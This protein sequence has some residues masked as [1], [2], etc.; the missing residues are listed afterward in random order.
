MT[1]EDE[2]GK[3]LITALRERVAKLEQS[4]DLARES[5]SGHQAEE[6]FKAMVKAFD[7]FIYVC[8]SNYEIEF[9]NQRFIHRIGR[10]PIGEKCYQVI[11]EVG[12]TCP[13]CAVGTLQLGEI[14]RRELQ[15]PKDGRWYRGA[16]TPIRGS[17]NTISCLVML[18]D[19][20]ERKRMQEALRESEQRFRSILE[21][22]HTVVLIIDPETGR[23]ED[24][25]LGACSF[26]G[27]SRDDLRQRN[28]FD[29]STLPPQ[30]I[31]ERKRMT[32]LQPCRYLESRHR[33]ASG[34]FRDV[35]VCSCPM[36]ISGKVLVFTLVND[37]TGRKMA[38]EALRKSE[39]RYRD[40][41]D[42]APISIL[43]HDFSEVQARFDRLRSLGVE[44]FKT[45]FENHPEEVR[46]CASMV[47]NLGV[48][49]ETVAL[50][51]APGKEDVPHYVTPYLEEESWNVVKDA[52]VALAEGK[53]RFEGVGTISTLT[54]EKKTLA[55]RMSVAE[56][57]ENAPLRVLL[58]LIDVTDR[59]RAEQRLERSVS[60]L[61]STLEATNDGIL[62]VGKD[63]N[64]VAYNQRLLDMWQ[65]PENIVANRDVCEAISF[66]LAD[67][68]NSDTFKDHLGGF[69]NCDESDGLD[70]LE[71]R[72]G[73]V[74]ECYSRPQRI[75]EQM[76]GR[77]LSFRDVTDREHW[78][79]ALQE[80][81]Q[82]NRLLIEESPVGIVLVQ[83]KKLTYANPVAL[84]MLGYKDAAE[85]LGR[86]AEDFLAPEERERIEK[87]RED[88]LAGGQISVPLELRGV[89]ENGE[90]LELARLATRNQ[91]PRTADHSG[92]R[93]GQ[94]RSQ[95]SVG[96]A[97]SF[98][99]DGSH[100][101]S[102]W[103]DRARFQ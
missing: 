102:S 49:Q 17:D 32:G 70:V 66:A 92:V 47:K 36:V 86:T 34:E 78:G 46:S 45:Y 2:A 25:S 101:H 95:E 71:F 93:H 10:N 44:D 98:P 35:E 103:R 74:F 89:K 88:R 99:E 97:P 79:N 52:F 11:H 19:I 13:W 7:G 31:F 54:G 40:L 84:A 26:Y 85:V 23:I 61:R 81:E 90:V 39:E 64:I 3:E 96:A 69:L 8:S 27:Y 43:E 80:S 33:M 73:R 58:S 20:T 59:K 14:E 24:G 75:G 29:I 63:K 77:V 48:N 30:A 1:D 37:V 60:L 21:N 50:F 9:I 55:F 22:P 83:D 94:N 91:S 42:S 5:A 65:V 18:E 87:L 28:V 68:K 53:T 12:D 62:V 76:I 15:S 100:W 67:L 72:D 6:R 56:R 41:F 38:E 51:Q 4:L 57:R 82:R 16:S